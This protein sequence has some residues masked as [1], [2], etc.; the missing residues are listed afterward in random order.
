MATFTALK[1][2]AFSTTNLAT[3][4]AESSLV[5][6]LFSSKQLRNLGDSA[7]HIISRRMH[8][9]MVI[10]FGVYMYCQL[11]TERERNVA[12]FLEIG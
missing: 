3:R 6:A 5:S 11:R 2:R 10:L 9:H 1:E 12:K 7:D 8:Q 4:S